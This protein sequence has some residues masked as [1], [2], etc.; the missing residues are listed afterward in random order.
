MGFAPHQAAAL[1]SVIGLAMM[2]GSVGTGAAARLLERHGVSVYAFCGIGMGC[3]VL[4]QIAI[5]CGAPLPAAVLWAAYGAFGGIGI[6]SYAILAEH[7]PV[8]LIGRANTTLTLVIFLLI[9]GFQLGVGAVLSQ[10]PTQG[11]RITRAPPIWPR[12]ACWG[13]RSPARSGTY[14]P[15]PAPNRAPREPGGAGRGFRPSVKPL[16]HNAG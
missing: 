4:T 8:Y 14:C 6:L 11:G 10:W 15:E 7:F 2:A 1:V 9:F 5:M 13:G 3:F 16:S 12:G